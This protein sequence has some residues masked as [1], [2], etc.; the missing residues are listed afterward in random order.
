MYFNLPFYFNY[1]HRQI[2][3]DKVFSTSKLTFYGKHQLRPRFKQTFTPCSQF[4]YR[5][6]VCIISRFFNKN[7]FDTPTISNQRKVTKYT[8]SSNCNNNQQNHFGIFF[9]EST[10][11]ISNI[12]KQRKV[13]NTLGTISNCNNEQN[14]VGI[15]F[16][17]NFFFN[18]PTQIF[19]QK[20]YRQPT[21]IK[22]RGF[23]FA[24]FLDIGYLRATDH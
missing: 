21:F 22:F 19:K 6:C 17:F 3:S 1:Y 4:W 13:K 14:N 24:P 5:M 10:F 15:Y 20:F 23:Y 7:T 9:N 8:K 12:S 16:N 11:D 2:L 18:R